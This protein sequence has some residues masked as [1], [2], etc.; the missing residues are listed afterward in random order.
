MLKGYQ[1]QNYPAGIP[2]LQYADDTT[3][4]MVGSVEKARNL[5]TILDLFADF[6]GLQINRAKSTFVGFGVT[7]DE[8]LPCSEA[9]GMPRGSLPT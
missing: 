6:S 8:C 4:F 9:L 7:Q 3:F 2:L 5:S 1:T